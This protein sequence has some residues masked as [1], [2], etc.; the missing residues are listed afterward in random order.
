MNKGWRKEIEKRKK[1]GMGERMK[2]GMGKRIK[3]RNRNKDEE[4]EWEK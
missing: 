2:N 3:K 1:K 4:K